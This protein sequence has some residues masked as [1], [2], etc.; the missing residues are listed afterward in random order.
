MSLLFFNIAFGLSAKATFADIAPN[1][2]ES[3]GWEALAEVY[4]NTLGNIDV[5]AGGL[6]ESVGDPGELFSHVILDQFNRIRNADRWWFENKANALFTDDEIA[7]IHNTSFADVIHRVTTIGQGEIQKDVFFHLAGDP[8]PQPKQLHPDDM[9]HCTEGHELDFY[10]DTGGRATTGAILASIACWLLLNIV[11]I[12]LAIHWDRPRVMRVRRFVSRCLTRPPDS[13]IEPVLR[14]AGV[15]AKLSQTHRGMRCFGVL[16]MSGC[17]AVPL[18]LV[19]V[20]SESGVNLFDL[21]MQECV[22]TMRPLNY[23]DCGIVA[24]RCGVESSGDPAGLFLHDLTSHDLYVLFNSYEDRDEFVAV[25]EGIYSNADAGQLKV[26]SN[27]LDHAT[28]SRCKRPTEERERDIKKI[29]MV[30]KDSNLLT[31]LANREPNTPLTDQLIDQHLKNFADSTGI[32]SITWEDLERLCRL[33]TRQEFCKEFG[34]PQNGSYSRRICDMLSLSN[35]LSRISK[36][37]L[38]RFFATMA[39]PDKEEKMRYIFRIYDDDN[40]GELYRRELEEMFLANLAANHIDLPTSSDIKEFSKFL[41]YHAGVD[42]DCDFMTADQFVTLANDSEIERTMRRATLSAAKTRRAPTNSLQIP[43]VVSSDSSAM[44]T[45]PTS[46]MP[47]TMRH[48]SIFHEEDDPQVA[49]DG[50]SHES[51]VVRPNIRDGDDNTTATSAAAA[52]TAT[53]AATAA[54]L[55][56]RRTVTIRTKSQIV[57]NENGFSDDGDGVQVP[58]LHQRSHSR[59]SNTF[60][61]MFTSRRNSTSPLNSVTPSP[62][63]FSE[64]TARPS[65]SSSIATRIRSSV[66]K[67]VAWL[68]GALHAAR[69]KRRERRLEIFWI[70]IYVALISLIFVERFIFYG[71]LRENRG[72]RRIAGFGIAVTRGSASVIMFTLALLLLPMCRNTLAVART[73]RLRFVVPF[74]RVVE[75]HTIVGW[76]FVIA[77]LVHSKHI[78]ANYE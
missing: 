46:L 13:N 64:Y 57:L 8:C 26:A 15:E 72:L 11:G 38:I 63:R 35:D 40:S 22:R 18:F 6:V 42:D 52:A 27:V 49:D 5:W 67:G 7:M 58:E 24:Y 36:Y 25:L 29:M 77:A 68:R 56:V 20:D 65:R 2:T 75:F 33:L 44:A 28:A 41:F 30:S 50:P 32:D 73:T 78:N 9:E 14:V 39:S 10:N 3:S 60:S 61:D 1:G 53:A 34:L 12:V 17:Q 54:N 43:R 62:Y 45:L 74:D 4:N 76:T 51:V 70:T 47:A 71:Y 55:R 19:A 59:A 16:D 66:S 37:S 48:H 23:V 69:A 21:G 31:F